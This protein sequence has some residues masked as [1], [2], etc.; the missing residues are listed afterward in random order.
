ME[1]LRTHRS[2]STRLAPGKFLI[3]HFLGSQA[4]MRPRSRPCM[5]TVDEGPKNARSRNECF[6]SDARV[7]G[8]F[9]A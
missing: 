7:T 6:I 4:A 8:R 1:Y 5:R 3:C 9:E 2:F